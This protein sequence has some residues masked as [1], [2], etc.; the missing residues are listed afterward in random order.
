M[1]YTRGREYLRQ[2]IWDY[3]IVVCSKKDKNTFLLKRR[4]TQG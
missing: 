2:I 3:D 4:S 1:I